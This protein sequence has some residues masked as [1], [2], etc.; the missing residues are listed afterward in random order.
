L[1]AAV[2]AVPLTRV[3]SLTA[4]EHQLFQRFKREHGKVYFD[5]HDESYRQQVFAANLQKIRAHDEKNATY[6]LAMN[7]FGDMTWEE[8]HTKMTGF[9]GDRHSYIRSQNTEDLSDVKVASS[10]DWETE[11]AVTPVKNQGQ[12]GSC[13]SFSATGAIEGAHY[14]ATGEL[15][16]LS[17]QNLRD[18]S[19]DEGNNSCEGGLMDYAF[20]YVAVHGI[21]SEASYPYAEK[22]EYTCKS[23]TPVV[24]TKGYHDVAVLESSLEAAV[25][26][27][28]VSI[29]IEADQDDFQFYSGGVFTSTCGT[30]LDH[31]VLAVGY[32]TLDGDDYWKVKNSWG[33]TWGLNGYILLEKGK[34][35]HGG[36]CG[37]LLSASYP[38]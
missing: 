10:V 23:C 34:A 20:E 27:G 5:V 3:G 13:W 6:T 29:A 32:G 8:F 30:N 14:I 4:E 38:I 18:C 25:T 26:K 7:E 33:P 22:D 17:E 11:G 21:C 35:Q 28:P 36:Q 15:I 16:S 19:K 9:L 24:R 2:V 1:F 31:G 37:I 12:C